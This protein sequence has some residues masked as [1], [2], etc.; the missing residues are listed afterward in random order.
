[1]INPYYFQCLKKDLCMVPQ[2]GQCDGVDPD[3]QLPWDPKKKCCPSSF[4]CVAQN[5][6]YSQCMPDPPSGACAYSYAQCGGKDADGEIWGSN[7]SKP[8]EKTCCI[9]GFHCDENATAP[10]W[11]RG[12][13]PDKLCTNP[14][15]G[16]CGGTDKA[17]HPWTPDFKHDAC[18]PD[19]FKCLFKSP[20][21]SQ[22]VWKNSSKASRPSPSPVAKK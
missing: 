7:A 3:T 14:R 17:G 16:Q 13:V 20:Y 8:E 19:G 15:F 11:F 1:V 2:F 4:H 22:C 21:Y 10:E 9:P 6:Y 5:P 12:C 18:C